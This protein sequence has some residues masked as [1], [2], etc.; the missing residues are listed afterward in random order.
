MRRDDGFTLL[1]II[2]AVVVLGFILAGLAQA[3]HFGINAWNVQAREAARVA[4]MERTDR[5]LR[6]VINEAAPPLS[7]DDKPFAGQEH[8]LE[9]ITRL[10]D[11]PETDLVR[12]A[13]VAIG[14]DNQHRLLLRWLPKPNAVALK[15]LPPPQEIV[16]A[17]GVDHLDMRYRQNLS[18]G[19]KWMP[20]W[21]DGAIPALVQMNIV[22]LNTHH[23]W[24]VIQVATMLDTNGSF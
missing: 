19:G 5:L 20:T 4:E 6:L 17:E 11:Q 12:R 24:P 16:L 2:V 23:I 1:E 18:D 3:S 9:F 15:R 14:V 10:P 13:Q 22:M 8:R 21:T 7:G